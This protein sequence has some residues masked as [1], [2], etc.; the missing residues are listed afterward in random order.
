MIS[1]T[2]M[3]IIMARVRLNA[4][5]KP[6]LHNNSLISGKERR[7]YW[8]RNILPVICLSTALTLP[9][10]VGVESLAQE[11]EEPSPVI[12]TSTMQLTSP[13]SALYFGVLDLGILGL[14]PLICLLYLVYQMGVALE[15]KNKR[16]RALR[17]FQGNQ[18]VQIKVEDKTRRQAKSEVK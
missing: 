10:L 2:F 18:E 7:I 4:I 13:Y 3:L 8:M 6:F 15:R 17:L 11:N 16:A 12:N 5:R 9:L 1:S 14:A